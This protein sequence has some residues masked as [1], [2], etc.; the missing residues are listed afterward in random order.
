MMVSGNWEPKRGTAGS[1]GSSD[2]S[3]TPFSGLIVLSSG[4]L[5]LRQAVSTS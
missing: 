5:I 2:V 4:L 3:K 1:R